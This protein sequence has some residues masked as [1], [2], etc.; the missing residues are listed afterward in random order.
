MEN[1]K[2]Q[3]KKEA[4]AILDAQYSSEENDLGRVTLN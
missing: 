3:I 4:K 2:P 1:L